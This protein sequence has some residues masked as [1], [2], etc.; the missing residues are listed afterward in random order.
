MLT[1]KEL[2]DAFVYYFDNP[3]F[4]KVNNTDIY[5]IYM[6]KLRVHL[7]NT[8][9]YLVCIVPRDVFFINTTRKQGD[10]H[11]V[12]FQTR[13]LTEPYPELVARHSY[14]PKRD[15]I[16]NVILKQIST[17]ENETKYIS[18]KLPIEVSL[19]ANDKNLYD[20]PKE[21]PLNSALETFNTIVCLK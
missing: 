1:N 13:S 16:F 14:Q 11:W 10:L 4:V 7:A 3:N 20:Y 12:V 19:L 5:S 15:N 2:Y 6:C 9:R 21:G 8:Y 17:T 18:D